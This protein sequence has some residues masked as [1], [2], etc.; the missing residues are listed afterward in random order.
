M[1]KYL[2]ISLFVVVSFCSCTPAPSQPEQ[3]LTDPSK[4]PLETT[5]PP[6][7]PDASP[8]F[9]PIQKIPVNASTPFS[10]FV[11]I[12]GDQFVDQNGPLRFIS[13]NIPNLHYNED[14]LK[15][16]QTND[17]RLPDE[18][19]I[20]DALEA[21]RQMGGQVVRTY[22]LSVRK[23]DDTPDIPRHVTGPGEFNE[24]A[25]VALDKVL[26]IAGEKQIRVILPF[27]NNWQ[28]W[29][30]I[31][32]YAGFRGKP[33]EAFWTDAAIFEDFKK[34][35]EYVIHRKNTFTGIVYKDDPAILGWQTGNELVCPHEWT[36]KTAA[37]IKSLDQNHLVIDAF[38]SETP[39]EESI[40]ASEI[41]VVTTHHYSEDPDSTIR[42][43]RENKLRTEGRKPYFVGEFG[44]L[45]TRDLQ[46]IMDTVIETDTS[47]ALIWSLRNRMREGGFYWHSEPMG[48]DLYKA[49]HWPGFNSG[50]AYDE[51]NVLRL[52]REKAYAIRNLPVPELSV[53]EPPV[54]LPFSDIARI[55]W[56]GSAG[57]E[58]YTLQR[59]VQPE[60]PWDT[61]AENVDDAWCQYRPLYTDT[62]ALPGRSYYYRILA[63]NSAGQ[64]QPSNVAGPV[65]VTHRTFVDEMRDFYQMYEHRG[66]L[67]FDSKEARKFKEDIH[68]LKASQ[69]ASVVYRVSGNIS[70]F[71]LFAFFESMIYE[72]LISA[73]SDGRTF[74]DVDIHSYGYFGG[75]GSYGYFKP[76]EY[77]GRVLDNN[78]QYLKIQFTGPVQISRIEI[79]YDR[80]GPYASHTHTPVDFV[81][82]FSWG[83]TGWRGQYS[84]EAA[85][86][87]ME[88]LAATNANWACISFGT[89]METFDRPEI[90]FAQTN[91]GM[92]TD[93]EILRAVQLARDNHL[94]V[95]LKPVV[96]VRDG[97]WR[98]WIKFDN[99]DGSLNMQA[100]EKWW[101]DFE[102]FLMHYAEI[103]QQT[104]CEMFCLG[105]EME[106]TEPFES[107][108]R[109]LISKIRQIYSGVLTYDAN[110]GR[111]EQIPWWDAV[112]VISLSAYYPVGTDDVGLA[113]KDDL[114]KVPPSDTSV[115]AMKKRWL[116]IKEQLRRVSRQYDRPILFIELGVCSAKGFSAAPWTHPQTDAVYDGDEQRR[117][118]QA[119]METFWDEPWFMG[120]AWWGWEPPLY[121]PE[122]AASDTGFCIYGKPAEELVTEWYGK[123]R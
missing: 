117:Y 19:E 61:I 5:P 69:D 47:G 43:I 112:D 32:E 107:K 96:N 13:F 120:F 72:P 48:G 26:Q 41:D 64:S 56:Q 45:P 87:S 18:Y 4:T 6:S 77:R 105:C 121:A 100:W 111:E 16:D 71:K 44:F 98:A 34:T 20:R 67:S 58:S 83:W 68:R 36:I 119:A 115:A 28:W 3:I 103:A 9:Y 113:L 86:E 97:T 51:K 88:K 66:E 104:Q 123:S 122:K 102:A 39:R 85:R 30:G 110:H 42:Q 63:Q 101:R 79:V 50:N 17:W 33:K 7:A 75:E 46:R 57:A 55:S 14:S 91:P 74:T 62:T 22:T 35:I 84:G 8:I 82:G 52:M 60:G 78:V 10:G 2:I 37:Y 49:Y 99:E 94:K 59:S 53:P 38:F 24:E 23:Q 1:R 27:V 12:Q 114:S 25:F 73:S 80:Q 40:T 29:G 65:F 118:F 21:V 15:F 76:V 116:P 108:W 95:I 70:D 11:R 54:L 109:A 93:E 106:S 81:K 31:A 89:E 90:P 92:V